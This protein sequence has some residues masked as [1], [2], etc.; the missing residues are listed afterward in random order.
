MKRTLIFLLL[1]FSLV[2][3]FCQDYYVLQVKG[4]VKKKKTGTLLKTK[5][6][7]KADEQL[8]FSS[9]TDAV[10][11]VN[12]KSGRFI[13]KP[14]K[15]DKGNEL[16]AYVKDALSQVSSRL[17]SRSGGFNNA[18]DI[19]TFF[20]ETI[21]LLPELRYKVNGQSFPIA[22]STFF[23]IQYKYRGEDI[24]K[25]LK[26]NADS[27]LIF[28]RSELFKIDGVSIAEAE[29]NEHQLFYYTESGTQLIAPLDFNLADLDKVINEINVLKAALNS[30]TYSEKIWDEIIAYL[31][32]NYGKVDEANVKRWLNK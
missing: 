20:A 3:A 25:Q 16:L 2:S 30:S 29:T 17:S 22:E 4:V 13:I 10:A 5:D 7:V 23:F 27:L 9:P 12:S 8:M 28:N 32:E 26:I 14:G 24:N 1:A 15:L 18:L 6:V 31:K 11:V 21:V 19:K